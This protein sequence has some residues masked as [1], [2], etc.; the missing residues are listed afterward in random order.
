MTKQ[1]ITALIW[2]EYRQHIALGTAMIVMCV[3]FQIA[4]YA[5]FHWVSP[6]FNDIVDLGYMIGCACVFTVIYT[7]VSSAIL[8]AKEKEDKTDHFLRNMP[9]TGNVVLVGKLIWLFGSMAALTVIFGIVTLVWRVILGPMNVTTETFLDNTLYFFVITFSGICH[10]LFWSSITRKQLHAI[11][12]TPASMYLLALLVALIVFLI[13]HLTSYQIWLTERIEYFFLPMYLVLTAVIGG[14]AV[15]NGG[16]WLRRREDK[17]LGAKID[18]VQ[19]YQWRH[20]DI[21]IAQLRAQKQPHGE[22]RWLLWQCY[23]QSSLLFKSGLMLAI[24]LILWPWIMLLFPTTEQWP[25]SM[26][27]VFILFFCV[28]GYIILCNIFYPDHHKNGIMVLSHRGIAPGKVWWSRIVLFGGLFAVNIAALW[29][30]LSINQRLG[31]PIRYFTSDVAFGWSLFFLCVFIIGQFA[32]VISRSL[33]LPMCYTGIGLFLGFWWGIYVLVIN[34]LSL[35]PPR[36]NVFTDNLWF[37]PQSRFWQILLIFLPV[38]LSFFVASR[39]RITDWMRDRPLRA[40][41]RK[42]VLTFVGGLALSTT[43]LAVVRLSTV[44]TASL[45]YQLDPWVLRQTVDYQANFN[46]FREIQNSL[47]GNNNFADYKTAWKEYRAT[48]ENPLQSNGYAF[49]PDSAIYYSIAQQVFR[50]DVTPEFL[51]EAIAF[52]EKMPSE[53]IPMTVVLQRS[54]EERMMSIKTGKSVYDTPNEDSSRVRARQWCRMI[55]PWEKV[56]A[57]RFADYRFQTDSLLAEQAERLVYHHEGNAQYLNARIQALQGEYSNR[58]LYGSSNHYLPTTPYLI[59]S[60]EQSRRV[61]ILQAALR[62]W[63]ME[64][65]ELPATLD[66]LKGTYLS[67]VPLTPFY[68]KPFEYDPK[69][70]DDDIYDVVSDSQGRITRQV[71]IQHVKGTPYLRTRLDDSFP[72]DYYGGGIYTTFVYDLSFVKRDEGLGTRDEGL[73][74]SEE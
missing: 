58:F 63:Y 15:W 42:L 26:S 9:I 53:R 30:S 34:D 45:G 48:I 54:Y 29:C 65:G 11:V 2:K 57:M 51:R 71:Q 66:E 16:R 60:I 5:W 4:M 44:P 8:F 37:S 74:G 23:R 52:L 19:N 39:L 3:L 40:S 33:I 64:H 61:A 55:A 70:G 59:Y 7:T 12:G 24:L 1:A 38:A 14:V 28:G 47:E 67:E 73:E 13:D 35:P 41:W 32:S 36:H 17:T 25:E 46:R 10:G 62:L 27:A 56:R 69:P 72:T 20:K 6:D 31:D 22:F 68:E 49:F 18:A 43:L 21:S 50:E